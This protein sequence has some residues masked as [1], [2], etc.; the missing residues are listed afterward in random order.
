[1]RTRTRKNATAG[2]QVHRL[3]DIDVEEVSIVDRAANARKF[4]VVKNDGSEDT[5]A[6]AGA[7]VKS[8]GK[9]GHTVEKETPPPAA[10]QPA[11][12]AASAPPAAPAPAADPADALPPMQEP[13]LQLSPEAKGELAKRV[14]AAK[15]R[16]EALEKMLGEAE[17]VQGLVEVPAEIVTKVSEILVGLAEGEKVEKSDAP[18]LVLKGLPQFSSARVSQLQAARD[19]LDALLGTVAPKPAEPA[20]AAPGAA[21]AE[22][23]ADDAAATVEGI[24]AKAM[25]AALAPLEEKVAKGLLGIAAK[26]EI[27]G[28]AIAK[29]A[30]RVEAL[31]RGRGG[32]QSA[33]A[34]AGDRTETSKSGEDDDGDAWPLDLA[35]PDKHRVEKAT[36]DVRFTR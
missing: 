33:P 15:G 14:A 9:G 19:A 31:D 1:M 8:D 23:V 26:V 28:T 24:V 36:S 13:K 25:K 16:L 2:Q 34:D 17:E 27:Q 35:D 20:P 22:P 7:P 29:Q 3:T 6:K 5:M 30:E 21:P 4:I 10:E 11:V 18:A 12:P 32:S